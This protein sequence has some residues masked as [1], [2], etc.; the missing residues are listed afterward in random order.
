MAW[1]ESYARW[2]VGLEMVGRKLAGC[3]S[4][5]LASLLVWVA[6]SVPLSLNSRA[7]SRLNDIRGIMCA[8]GDP[9]ISFTVVAPVMVMDVN[10]ETLLAS[11]RAK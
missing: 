8:S 1:L 11:Q 4:W 7:S 3:R 9:I 10:V 6:R 2:I 5:K